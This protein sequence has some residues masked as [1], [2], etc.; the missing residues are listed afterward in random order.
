MAVSRKM[1]DMVAGGSMIR[2]MFEAGSQLK[3]QYGEDKVCDFSIGNPDVEPPAA[4]QRTLEEIVHARIPL[5]HG[6]MANAGYT[7]TRAAVAAQVGKE[8]GVKVGGER[9]VM[10]CGAGGGLNAVLKAILNAGD[11]VIVPSPCFVEY[12]FYAG[13]HG[14]EV[15]F[16]KT[17]PDFDL[18]IA[19]VEALVT[20]DTA[21]VLINSPNNPTGRVYS[22]AT[23]RELG[24]MLTEKS[25]K[26][27]RNVYLVSDEPY[28]KIVYD[29]VVVPPIFPHYP[30]SIVVT[31]HS[32]DLSLPGERIG[33]VAVNPEAEDAQ[34]LTDAVILCTR[35]LGVVNAPALMQ[36]VVAR[37]QGVTVDVEVYRK[38]RDLLHGAL[39]E[40]G[41]RVY[42]PE[43]AF[44]LFPESF[45]ADEMPMV[46]ALRKERVLVVPGRGF[47]GPGHVRIAYCV[48]TAIIERSLPCFR[49]VA[50][51]LRG[52]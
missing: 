3:A 10:S 49:R 18:D 15:L 28:R 48:D 36:R 34:L 32:K 13:N 2:K 27:G 25:R 39:T 4:F 20:K 40:M 19:A 30:H 45:G 9:V 7:E 42:K 14:G 21:A 5:K 31:S 23:V 46:E 50:E 33:S 17:K 11:K 41:Y 12:G 24:R 44:Y 6:Y 38:K 22:E 37:L 52:G 1:A 29:G 51:R 43:G 8:Q 35:I 26:V 47:A 16:A